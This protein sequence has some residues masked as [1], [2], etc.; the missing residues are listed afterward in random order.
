MST[1]FYR[2]SRKVARSKSIRIMKCANI[3]I[4]CQIDRLTKTSKISLAQSFIRFI[5]IFHFRYVL[6]TTNS[7]KV[8][9]ELDPVKYRPIN[10]FLSPWYLPAPICVS[11]DTFEE[12][13]YMALYDLN[14]IDLL[15]M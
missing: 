12:Q 15:D 8:N 1:R 2:I 11:K 9:V 13:H 5:D 6:M 14:K 7:N 10:F 4:E 3:S